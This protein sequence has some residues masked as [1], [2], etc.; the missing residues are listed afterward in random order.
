MSDQP[1]GVS[2][3]LTQATPSKPQGKKQQ[4]TPSAA[5]GQPGQ[6]KRNRNRQQN[7]AI[8]ITQLD[9]TVS[10][11]VTQASPRSEKAPRQRQSTAVGARQAQNGQAGQAN[12]QKARPVSVGG[13][14]LAAGTP[15]KEQA[16]AGPTFQ[17]SPA[18]NKLPMPKFMGSRSVPSA[19][20]PAGLQ[21]RLAG[22]KTPPEHE[23]S[24]EADVVSPAP[25]PRDAAVQSPLDM[26]FQADR[27]ERERKASGTLSPPAA[28]RHM[29]PGS[30]PRNPFHD[31]NRNTFF[32]ALHE[33]QP[34]PKTVQPNSRPNIERARSSPGGGSITS[35]PSSGKH[36]VS[37]QALK[38][39]LFNTA[40]ERSTPPPQ[41][42]QSGDASKLTPGFE[43]PSP[44]TRR[45]GPSTPTPNQQ[46]NDY[47]LHYG[48]R[49]LSPMFQAARETPTRPSN[50]RQQLD[51]S[52]PAEPR[53][54]LSPN[55]FSR[56]YLDQQIRSSIPSQPP[57]GLI[58]NSDPS[59]NSF[60]QHQRGVSQ[61]N[62]FGSLNGAAAQHQSP[63][64]SGSRDVKGM[65]DDLRRMLRLS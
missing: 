16:Y 61:D 5:Q 9:G 55:A 52:Q 13:P 30:E 23:S 2:P 40:A 60:S 12:G 4:R 54:Q 50:L 11:S 25:P 59:L 51:Q 26:F 31:G 63:R 41:R 38:N 32:Q 21:A 45:S 35:P 17:A 58:S 8:P 34:S 6:G 49:N 15:V 48:N 7:P 33:D 37:T 56:S 3:S 18:P 29:P 46:Q 62:G 1:N 57:P 44:F 36:D 43:T 47:A 22:E 27:E 24:P 10:D 53:Q 14:L 42:P 64:N 20:H 19:A 28:R 65:E 39:L